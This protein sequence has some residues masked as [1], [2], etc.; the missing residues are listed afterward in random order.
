V[1]AVVRGSIADEAGL[2]VDDPLAVQGWTVDAKRGIAT[3][4]V[5]VRKRTAGFI[6][7]AVQIS[8]WIETDN[9]L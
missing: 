3:L 5:V 2:S 7:S 6:E 4:Q 1:R 8:A 9:F